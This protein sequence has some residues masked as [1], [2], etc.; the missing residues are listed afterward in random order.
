MIN[1][2]KTSSEISRLPRVGEE[3]RGIVLIDEIADL[4]PNNLRKVKN[5]LKQSYN[6]GD[7][8]LAVLVRPLQ[9]VTNNIIEIYSW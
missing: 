3:K 2:R 4:D 1:P 7:I 9:S 8:L 6:D 5:D